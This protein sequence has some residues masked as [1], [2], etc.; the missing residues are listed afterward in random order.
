MYYEKITD[1]IGNT[2]LIKIPKSTFNTTSTIY[3][4]LEKNNL[5]SSI[6][7]RYAKM[8]IENYLKNNQNKTLVI[9]TSG[10]LGIS[11]ASLCAI[12][13]IKCIIILPENA[14]IE[15]KKLIKLLNAKLIETPENL[16]M[17]ET[18]D[19]AKEITKDQNYLL[20]D[21][22]NDHLNL[23]VHFETT[24]KEIEN[25]L[26]ETPD[27]IIAGMGSSGTISGIAKYYKNKK[28]K[29]IALIPKENNNIPG[30]GPGF[31]PTICDLKNITEI[32]EISNENLNKYIPY[33]IRKTGILIGISGCAALKYAIELAK[34][35]DDKKIVVLI[36]DSYERYLANE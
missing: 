15:R 9:P 1:L 35:N 18:I 16:G 29:T 14:S 33:I 5:S 17:K 3:L 25:D 26:N 8:Y 21:Q 13:N 4:K 22:F 23:K 12:N 24:A 11:F 10:N 2:P 19:K 32:V 6:K 36:P 27:I 34:S 28:T 20:V 31:L 30:I 7:D